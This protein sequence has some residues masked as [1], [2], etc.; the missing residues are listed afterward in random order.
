MKAPKRLAII[1]ARSGSKRLPNKNVRCLAGWPLIYWTIR[2]ASDCFDT[3]VVTSDS[4]EVLNTA[5]CSLHN[6]DT[7]VFLKRP[8]N[9]ATDQSKVIDTVSYYFDL[10]DKFNYDEVWLLLPTCPLREDYH[11]REAQDMLSNPDIDGVL[12]ITD[13]EFP[14]TLHLVRN[15]DGTLD[16]WGEGHPF[17]EGNSR[18]QDQP[19]TYRPNGAL[20]GMK[21]SAFKEYRNFYQGRVNGYYMPR[22]KSVDIDTYTDFLLAKALKN[23]S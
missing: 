21:W 11:I 22:E 18:S 17:A 23:D 20:Y 9:L 4:Q 1:P 2:A 8:K 15:D 19:V 13:P 12:S 16:G 14:P 3:I 5:A 6:K 7:T 10:Y